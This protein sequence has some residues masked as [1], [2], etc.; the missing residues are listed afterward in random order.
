MNTAVRATFI[1]LPH[2]LHV[3]PD[4][5]IPSSKLPVRATNTNSRKQ[6]DFNKNIRIF[7]DMFATNRVTMKPSKAHIWVAPVV[8]FSF[9]LD[10]DGTALLTP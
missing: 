4:G 9:N 7:G 5:S 8:E 10:M 1:A 6:T 2:K 3:S